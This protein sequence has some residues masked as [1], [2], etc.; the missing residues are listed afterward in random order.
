[1]SEEVACPALLLHGRLLRWIKTAQPCSTSL[2]QAP[3]SWILP[4]TPQG[5]CGLPS[6]ASLQGGTR[7]RL[8]YACNQEFDRHWPK[9]VN[10]IKTTTISLNTTTTIVRWT[11][12]LYSSLG[13]DTLGA[14]RYPGQHIRRLAVNPT[15]QRPNE[16]RH[17]LPAKLPPPALQRRLPSFVHPAYPLGGGHF[18]R[19]S[20]A[21]IVVVVVFHA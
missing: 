17:Y 13:S 16:I 6:S 20:F 1:L 3:L 11:H 8:G 9:T 12:V 10:R 7:C 15:S 5:G 21:V 19:R 14:S 18:R 4:R 2:G